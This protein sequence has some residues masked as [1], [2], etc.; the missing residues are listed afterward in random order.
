MDAHDVDELAA[1]PPE[2]FVAAR[3]A[4]AQELK[5]AGGT[6]A[7]AAVKALR[8][9]T[10]VE[11]IAATV[12][13]ERA[14]A[15][16]EL[17]AALRA[18]AAAQEAALTSRDRDGLRAATAQR[19]AALETVERAID[20]VYRETDRPPQ[21]RLEVRQIIEAQLMAQVAPG[22]FGMRDDLELPEPPKRAEPK[23]KRDL[24]AE[25]RQSEATRA[26]ERAD[27][28]VERAR[29]DLDAAERERAAVRERYADVLDHE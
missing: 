13:R 22:T 4:P 12:S 23:R 29:A 21:H 11:W 2:A 20:D 25:R 17:R 19:H 5:G 18:V 10:V 28:A 27:A 3:N 24:V 15:V 14:D 26:I 16:D 9:P 6:E 1:G 7:A 8:K